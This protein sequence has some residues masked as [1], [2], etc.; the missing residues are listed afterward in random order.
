MVTMKA[1]VLRGPH[2]VRVEEV[3]RPTI[4]DPG[5][6]LLRVELTAICGTDLH[7]YEGRIE[8]EDGVILGHEFIGTVEDAGDAV[9]QVQP[10]DRVVAS[11]VVNCGHCWV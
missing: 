10:G 6:V 11:C 1:A 2:D 8:L 5:D 9:G 3:A 4:S 7:P